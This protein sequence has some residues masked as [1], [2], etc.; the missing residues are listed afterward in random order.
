MASRTAAVPHLPGP[1]SSRAAILVYTM[2]SVQAKGPI[3][4]MKLS[5][6]VQTFEVGGSITLTPTTTTLLTDPST[7]SAPTPTANFPSADGTVPLKG[8]GSPIAEHDIFKPGVSFFEWQIGD[9][10][11]TDSPVGDF[12]D[13]YPTEFPFAGQINAYTVTVSGITQLH[14][15]AYNHTV[16]VRRRQTNTDY[17]FAPFSHDANVTVP[18]TCEGDCSLVPEPG[19]LLFLGGGLLGL[20]VFRRFHKNR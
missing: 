16:E 2:G 18:N 9:F 11:L 17:W 5:A 1:S 12:I 4:G 13:T 15:D 14:F 10:T 19:T 3:Y 8:D 7:P 6:A 20:V